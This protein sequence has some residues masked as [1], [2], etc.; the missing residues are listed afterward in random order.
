[1]SLDLYYRRLAFYKGRGG[2]AM[3]GEVTVRLKTPPVIMP[4]AIEVDYGESHGGDLIFAP[5]IRENAH[6]ERRSM[7]PPEIDVI[8]AFLRTIWLAGTGAAARIPVL[9][10]RRSD[11]PGG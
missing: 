1:M 11:Q 5:F 4:T 3:E 9:T 7:S 6:S 2:I 10:D 8:K